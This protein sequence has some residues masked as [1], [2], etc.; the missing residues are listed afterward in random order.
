MNGGGRENGVCRIICGSGRFLMLV[1]P[2]RKRAKGLLDCIHRQLKSTTDKKQGFRGGWIG[3][4]EVQV[5][6]RPSK[7]LRGLSFAQ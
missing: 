3:Y 5:Y 4:E 7:E 2:G 1:E 6:Q